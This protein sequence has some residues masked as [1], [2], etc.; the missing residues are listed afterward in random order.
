MLPLT[1]GISRLIPGFCA[2]C[3]ALAGTRAVA[4]SALRL[5]YPDPAAFGVRSASTYDEAGRRVGDASIRLERLANE[6]VALGLR[7]GFDRGA[8]IELY[9]ELAPTQVAGTR[10]LRILR[11]RSQSFDP[12]GKP[13]VILLIDHEQGEASC[14][15]PDGEGGKPSVL[16]LPSPDRVVNVPLNLLFQPLGLGEVE[17]V[18][19]QAFFC[20]GGARLMGFS[21][22]LAKEREATNPEGRQIREVRY[23][24]DGKNVFSWL[25]KTFAP[26]ISFWMDID[27]TGAYIAH[28]MPLYS[29]GPVVYVIADGIEPGSIIAR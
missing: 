12:E 18:E 14:T 19:T 10:M 15:P 26:K 25:A 7:S 4:E 29:K 23:G 6:H 11:E 5:P 22:R 17:S 27:D 2:L 8:R 3:F 9:A 16:S 1:P 24:P 28:R 20:L 21:A 13:L